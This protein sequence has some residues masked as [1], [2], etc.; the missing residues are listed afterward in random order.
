M[1]LRTS[2][3]L[4]ENL[5]FVINI[6]IFD[7]VISLYDVG[8]HDGY[9]AAMEYVLSVPERYVDKTGWFGHQR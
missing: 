9:V 8:A 2:C 6:F 5:E 7:I 3:L 4:S 1:T